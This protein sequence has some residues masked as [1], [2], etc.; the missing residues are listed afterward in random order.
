MTE[1]ITLVMGVASFLGGAIAMYGAAVRK[2]YGSERDFNHLKNNYHNL[3]G[4][5]ATLSTLLDEKLD[6]IRLTL[7]KI[8]TRQSIIL[9]QTKEPD[10]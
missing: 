8:E 5:I 7:T 10:E 6:D 4:N 9:N 3:S 1:T 2:K